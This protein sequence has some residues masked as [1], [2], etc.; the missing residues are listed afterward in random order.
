MYELKELVLM[1]W[2]F[3]I[4][5]WARLPQVVAHNHH[6]LYRLYHSGFAFRC[7]YSIDKLVEWNRIMLLYSITSHTLHNVVGELCVCVCVHNCLQRQGFIA[8]WTACSTNCVAPFISLSHYSIVILWG[9]TN[10]S[11]YSPFTTDHMKKKCH[12]TTKKPPK[13]MHKFKLVSVRQL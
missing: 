1:D 2:F 12:A 9:V 13:W 4:V 3:D 11:R 10:Y 7:A 8:S 5:G 6:S